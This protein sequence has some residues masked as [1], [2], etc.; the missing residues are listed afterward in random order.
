M[1]VSECNFHLAPKCLQPTAHHVLSMAGYDQAPNKN[2]PSTMDPAP[3]ID[4]RTKAA[5]GRPVLLSETC[6]TDQNSSS[7]DHRA[8]LSEEAVRQ[9]TSLPT[10]SEVGLFVIGDKVRCDLGRDSF[11][12]PRYYEEIKRWLVVCCTRCYL[13]YRDDKDSWLPVLREMVHALGLYW[14]DFSTLGDDLEAGVTRPEIEYTHY[15]PSD[16][17][18]RRRL[19]LQ[20]NEIYQQHVSRDHLKTQPKPSGRKRKQQAQVDCDEV[21]GKDDEEDDVS[22]KVHFDPERRKRNRVGNMVQHL[23]PVDDKVKDQMPSISATASARL[24]AESRLSRAKKDP[25]RWMRDGYVRAEHIEE[26]FKQVDKDGALI[27]EDSENIRGALIRNMTYEQWKER[28]RLGPEVITA[29]GKTRKIRPKS[30][31]DTHASSGRFNTHL[32]QERRVRSQEDFWFSIAE[33]THNKD[34][35]AMYDP[36]KDGRTRMRDDRKDMLKWQGD[37]II[38]QETNAKMKEEMRKLRLR[39]EKLQ[40]DNEKLKQH[41]KQDGDQIDDEGDK[42]KQDSEANEREAEV[43]SDSA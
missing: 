39:A 7:S 13:N 36:S 1:D 5:S 26:L 42:W 17:G 29:R 18:S 6:R 38:M 30:V 12:S 4:N 43:A 28:Q 37:R 23:G 16:T 20:F 10:T 35:T 34:R 33:S 19:V 32:H 25:V 41:E 40:S 22:A 11:T 21:E 27:I 31:G 8:R 15:E 24:H 9:T 2:E 3:S 14:S